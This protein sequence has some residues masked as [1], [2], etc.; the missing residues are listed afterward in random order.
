MIAEAPVRAERGRDD[1]TGA[2]RIGVAAY[3]FIYENPYQRVL[4]DELARFGFDLDTD[5]DFRISWL[6]RNRKR[7]TIVHFH[8]PQNCY[9]WFRR[10]R[11]LRRALSWPKL[12]LFALRLWVARALGY[13][14][15]WTVHEV[16][17]HE[18]LAGHLDVIA[19]KV[20][21]RFS[22]LLIAHDRGTAG[23]AVEEFKLTSPPVVIPHGSYIDIYPAGR[24]RNAV[25]AELGIGPDAPTF[26]YFGHLRT[27]KSIDVLLDA[28]A[29][30][31]LDDVH[32]VIAGIPL[33]EDVERVVR[34]AEDA[35]ER[36]CARL[37]FVPDDGVAELFAAADVVV[38]PRSDGG[39]SGALVLA[40]SMSRPAVVADKA[41]YVNLI[42]DGEAG[43]TFAAGDRASLRRALESA[44]ADRVLWPRKSAA[45]RVIAEELSWP[46]IAR[47]TAA[48]LRRLSAGDQP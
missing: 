11:R 6:F 33:D 31:E 8:W 16:F 45:A 20:L 38:L 24:S 34:S 42:A 1:A 19:A 43:W 46:S 21:A 4:Y 30:A 15:V 41:D 29:H 10:P 44:V 39:T 23:R 35:D 36:I 17:P 14:V 32:L 9:V 26:L 2:Q 28:F 25:R 22:D 13:S 48:A 18:R 47:R 40:L 3:P 27:Y 37:E 7:T 5:A 12:A